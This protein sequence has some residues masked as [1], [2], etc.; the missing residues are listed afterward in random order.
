MSIA[1]SS[2]LNTGNLK[3]RCFNTDD[4]EN[5]YKGL[6]D[7]LVT[8][9]YAV[10]FNSLEE[11]IE[12]LN[13]YTNLLKTKTG[14]WWAIYDNEDENFYGGIGLNDISLTN[15]SAEIGFWLL[16]E[17][18]GKGILKKVMPLV[19]NYAFHNL[20]IQELKAY[21]ESENLNCKNLLRKQNFTLKE[22]KLN[23]EIKNGQ[24]ISLAIFSKKKL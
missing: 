10:H 1:S 16:P 2:I 20:N 8:K 12:Q 22:T 19:C 17:F 18:W 4:L 7:P 24:L 21:V 13:W 23:C 6:S 9:Y 11:T 5:I 14:I 3:L 15:K